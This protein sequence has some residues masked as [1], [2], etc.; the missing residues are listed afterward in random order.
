M[1]AAAS[2]EQRDASGASMNTFR[3]LRNGREA[4]DAMLDNI[5]AAQHSIRL[6]TFIFHAGEIGDA[7]RD[8]LIAA[9]K[10]GVRVRVMCDAFGS[11]K[12]LTSYWDG[13]V[14][15]G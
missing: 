3:W 13:L 10:R 15:A 6:E 1:A 11:L 12:L 14:A 7:F 9:Q 2:T 4:V 5:M 8:A